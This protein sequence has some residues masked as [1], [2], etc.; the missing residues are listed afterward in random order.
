VTIGETLDERRS[1]ARARFIERNLRGA[2][3]DIG[4]VTIDQ[5]ALQPV[6]RGTIRRRLRHG[7]HITDRRVLH[8]E[9]VFADENHWQLPHRGKIER[10]VKSADICRAV[11][12]EADRYVLIA[13]VLS[14]PRGATGDGK[15]SADDG[16]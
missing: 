3:D 7:R 12:K 1:F 13:L 11:A 6:S 10:L 15:M 8:V 9:I 4:I 5:D 2:I 14:A 16:V